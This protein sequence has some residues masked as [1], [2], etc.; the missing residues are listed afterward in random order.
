MG[1]GSLYPLRAQ[2]ERAS[3]KIASLA[4]LSVALVLI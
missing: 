1:S 2:K 4:L 3:T